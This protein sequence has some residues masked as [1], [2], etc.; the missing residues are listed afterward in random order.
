M[1]TT[2]PT[3]DP[4]FAA[5]QSLTTPPVPPEITHRIYYDEATRECLRKTAATQADHEP[6]PTPEPFVIVS[7]EIYD[8]VHFCPA[9]RV[10][11]NQEISLIPVD[12]TATILLRC[13]DTGFATIKDNNIFRVDDAYLGDTDHWVIGDYDDE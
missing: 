10:T 13:S 1:P 9:F 8:T 7:R 3:S 2:E 12:N 4:L 5:L 6:D 11:L